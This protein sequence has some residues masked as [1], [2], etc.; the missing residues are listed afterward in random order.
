[1]SAL[2]I[3]RRDVQIGVR[4]LI[5]ARGLSITALLTLA[6]GIGANTTIFTVVNAVLLK[7]LPYPDAERLVVLDEYRLHHGSRTVSWLDFN[8]WKRQTNVFEDLAAYR[9][10]KMTLSGVEESA[11]LRVAEVSAPFFPLLGARTALGRNFGA[12]EDAAGAKPVI[13]LSHALWRERLGGATTLTGRTLVLNGVAYEVVGVLPPDFRFFDQREDLYMPVG[14]RSGDP[15]WNERSTHPNLFVLAKLRAGASIDSGRSAMS[16]VMSRLERLYP[17]TNTG[18]LASVTGLYEYRFGTTRTNLLALFASVGCILLIACGNV[19]NLLLA[20][21]A[22]RTKE[23]AI[24]TAIGASRGRLIGQLIVESVVLAFF[25]GALGVLLA[26]GALR[27]ILAAIP[28]DLPFLA[29]SHI[30]FEVLAFTSTVSLVTGL[31]VGVV[32]ALQATWGDL[33]LG[34]TA[35]GR[36]GRS[37]RTSQRIQSAL[38]I[39]EI[40][41]A[42]I[43]T[44]TAALFVNSLRNAV[45]VNPGFD[46]SHVL[47][48]DLSVPP[49]RYPNPRNRAVLF[50]QAVERLNHLPG[51]RVAGAAL[52]PPLVGVCDDSSFMLADHPVRSVLDLPTAESNIVAPGYFEAMQIPL[53]DG[54]L[55]TH[56][57]NNQT[58][59]VAIVNQTFARR[60][61]PRES[62]VGKRLREGGPTGG[63]PYRDIVGVV[64]DVKQEGMDVDARPEVFLPVTQFPFAPWTALEGMTFV[65]RTMGHPREIAALAKAEARGADTDLPVIGVRPLAEYIS[66]SLARRKFL[67][68]LL[69]IFAALALLL[70]AIGTYG[71]MA[72]RVGQRLHEISLRMA[73]GATAFA[74]RRLLLRDILALASAGI[75]IGGIGA[76]LSTRLVGTL[77]LRVRP[78]DP[79]VIAE[80]AVL[81]L[82]VS[83]LA[84]YIP[85]R[86]AIAVDPAQVLRSE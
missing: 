25:G 28:N 11:L 81:L 60:Y 59:L 32:P 73:L 85:A 13:V 21:G 44:A 23:M 56:F 61:W 1:M 65:V 18:L 55:F 72:Y 29:S 24:R 35:T 6:L 12:S 78:T 80:V 37:S 31:M 3:G 74:I 8:D 19:A 70:S 62:A 26:L 75:V 48:L 47:A 39:S 68:A 71:I 66:D 34:L 40:A 69:A 49:N 4:G 67:T 42:L 2:D 5:K 33:N 51:V 53:T 7:R 83:V 45:N 16:V 84:G 52:C 46:V 64:A 14:L 43:V 82:L 38:V 30:D 15:E 22:S 77:L 27:A 58:R 63:Q 79:S 50:A 10:S 9:L 54:R 86:R 57:D 36:G 20:R 41:I 76:F 17:Q